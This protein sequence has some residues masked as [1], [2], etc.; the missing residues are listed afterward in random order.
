MKKFY[1]HLPVLA[2]IMLLTGCGSST[3]APSDESAETE[4]STKEAS[5]ES[6]AP[7]AESS[8]EADSEPADADSQSADAETS[9]FELWEYVGYVDECT[10]YTWRAEFDNCDY[11]GDGKTDRVNRDCDTKEESAIYTIK[12]GN[13]DELVTPK[14]WDTGFPHIQSGDLDGDGA[15]EILVTLTYDTSTDPF[16]FGDMWLFHKDQTTGQ[17]SQV[18]LPLANGEN[19]AKGFTTEYDEPEDGNIKYTFK[20]AGLSATEEVGEDYIKD[21]WTTDAVTEIRPVFFAEIINEDSPV[22]RCYVTPF[23]RLGTIMGFN[24]NYNNGKYEIGYIERD[25]PKTWA[26]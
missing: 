3:T 23:P 17:Y 21:W 15:K 14:G 7:A 20:E 4:T 26:Q 10:N 24:L 12:F 18:E 5:I 22:L 25:E 13:G 16:S 1:R 2:M 19:G 6:E 8:V 11:D 9:P